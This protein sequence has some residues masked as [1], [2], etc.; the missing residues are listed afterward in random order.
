MEEGWIQSLPPLT[1]LI[2]AP[3]SRQEWGRGGGGSSELEKQSWLKDPL[4]PSPPPP[5]FSRNSIQ[6]SPLDPSYSRPGLALIR[7][8]QGL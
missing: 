1:T 3:S 6:A 2:S 4:F 8:L 5:T 7:D